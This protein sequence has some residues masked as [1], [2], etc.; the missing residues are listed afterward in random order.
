MIIGQTVFGGTYLSPWFPRRGDA[1]IFAAELIAATGTLN[2]GI[3]TKNAE[4]T[5]VAP[6]PSGTGTF[7][8]S[9]NML[10]SAPGVGTVQV[11]GGLKELV[12][13][14]YG[15]SSSTAWVHFRVLPPAWRMNGA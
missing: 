9:G 7:T 2:F 5:D 15:V 12:R 14:Y 1:A 11:T 3:Q 6:L 4:E 13:F 10:G 8:T